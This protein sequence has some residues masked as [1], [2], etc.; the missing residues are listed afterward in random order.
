MFKSSGN[1]ALAIALKAVIDNMPAARE[2]IMKEIERIDKIAKIDDEEGDFEEFDGIYEAQE[3][4]R[5]LKDI[6]G[7][8]TSDYEE[9]ED[10]APSPRRKKR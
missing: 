8:D 5:K 1:Q 2:E 4:S 6:L 10:N 3:V 7:I 9:E